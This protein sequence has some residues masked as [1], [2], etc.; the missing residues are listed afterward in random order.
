MRREKAEKLGIKVEEV[1]VVEQ[2]KPKIQL[3]LIEQLEVQCQQVQVGMNA[4]PEKAKVLFETLQIYVT[5]VIKNNGEE[6]FRK[7]NK[8]NKAFQSRITECFGWEEM[9]QVL[10]YEEEGGFL[11]MKNYDLGILEKASQTLAR[12]KSYY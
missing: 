1:E 4:Y 6:K 2:K 10:G 9:M 12:Y 3:N 8:E 5:N 11:L 7:I